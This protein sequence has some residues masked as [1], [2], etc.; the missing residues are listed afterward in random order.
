[1]TAMLLHFI[2][3]C[4]GAAGI[5]ELPNATASARRPLL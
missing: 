3:Y 1:M 2:A 5:A 4:R